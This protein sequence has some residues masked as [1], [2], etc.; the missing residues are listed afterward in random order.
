MN[1]NTFT[2]Q[3]IFSLF[4]V[5]GITMD[6]AAKVMQIALLGSCECLDKKSIVFSVMPEKMKKALIQEMKPPKF[7]IT[8]T[9]VF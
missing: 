5:A 6:M 2:G 3:G 7:S 4:D 9:Q 8:D 1:L